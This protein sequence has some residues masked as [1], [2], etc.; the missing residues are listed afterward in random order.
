[1]EALRYFTWSFAVTGVGPSAFAA[2]PLDH[3]S[4]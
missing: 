4:L 3:N 2:Q 1:M